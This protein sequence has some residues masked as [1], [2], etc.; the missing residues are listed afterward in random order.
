[1]NDTLTAARQA[2]KSAGLIAYGLLVQAVEETRAKAC[3]RLCFNICLTDDFRT[4]YDRLESRIMN[5]FLRDALDD[6]SK[7]VSMLQTLADAY[8]LALVSDP[9]A[10]FFKASFP[11]EISPDTLDLLRSFMPRLH[12]VD[13]KVSETY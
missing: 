9:L 5:T 7:S 6:L 10:G 11:D 13:M 1:M 4:L 12:Y 2:R 3:R 8:Q